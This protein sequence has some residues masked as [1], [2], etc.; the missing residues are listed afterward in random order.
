MS[1][2]NNCYLPQPPRAWSRVQNSCSLIT[3]TDNNGLVRDPYTG[4]LV[5][6]TVLA[7]RIAMLNKGNVLQYKAN[8]SNLT[9]SQKY[10]KIA[11]GQWVNRN[12]TWATQ[13]T[14]G[15]TNPNTSSL[16]RSG[17]VEN[18]AIDPITGAI[19]G[20][21][22]A[23]PT[24]P[25]PVNPVNPGLPSNGGGGSD[26]NDPDIPPPVEP[27]P[28]SETFPP[29]IPVTPVEPTVIQDGGSLLCSVQENICTGEIKSS[30]SQILCHPTTD[31]D[32]P[33]TIQDLCWNDGLQ[34]WYPRSRY[35]MTNSGNKWPYTSGGIENVTYVSAIKPLPPSIISYYTCSNI[36]FLNWTQTQN[37]LPIDRYIIYNNDIPI[38]IVDSKTFSAEIVV[39]NTNI[40]NYVYII[41]AYQNILSDK[42]NTI[43]IIFDNVVPEPINVTTILTLN[44]ITVNWSLPSDYINNQCLTGFNLYLN[45]IFITNVS[46]TTFTYTFTSLSWTDT[47]TIG[48]QTTTLNTSSSISTTSPVKFYSY[49]GTATTGDSGK[50]HYITFLTSGTVTFYTD[51]N[52]TTGS[53]LAVG[54]G[55]GGSG[56]GCFSTPSGGYTGRGGAGGGFGLISSINFLQSDY[57]IYNINGGGQGESG[58][59]RGQNGGQTQIQNS[60]SS[61]VITCTGGNGGDNGNQGG[62]CTINSI[63][64]PGNG[65]N[66]QTSATI[67][68][69]TIPAELSGVF[70]IKY[71]GG[72]GNGGGG[73]STNG[74]GGSAGNNG[75]AGSLGT[76]GSQNGQNANSYGSGGGGGGSRGGQSPSEIETVG[77]NGKQGF[78]AFWW[79]S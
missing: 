35:V 58:D 27:T 75:N 4:Q 15:Y 28:G 59:T 79:S 63:L 3:D 12:T 70:T 6:A 67:A 45:G 74:S 72:G 61:Q 78:A 31:S 52:N 49:T 24:C 62:T 8:S 19:I 38:L 33:G 30:L 60:L 37:C 54:G 50:Y 53:V 69:L 32:V 2:F 22:T 42:S 66:T 46:N 65:G 44:N 34:T 76:G 51:I 20:P 55:G 40:P 73:S 26:V 56:G 9:K 39:T 41:S 25:Q 48:I 11:K 77:G 21:T 10:S 23:P 71:S 13:S 57:W 16:K 14:R 64:Q 29:I 7:E 17:N 43:N 18:I 47:Y 1:C 5:P 68:D 36:V